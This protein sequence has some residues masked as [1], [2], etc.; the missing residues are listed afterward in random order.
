M[1]LKL[2]SL[3]SQLCSVKS[4]GQGSVLILFNLAELDSVDHSLLLQTS[5]LGL[6]DP[7]G[8]KF[9]SFLT[10]LS[11]LLCW[12][13]P[14]CVCVCVCVCARAR[15]HACLV[16]SLCDPINCSPP[17]S[18]VHGI[19]QARILKWVATCYSRG[20]SQPRDQTCVS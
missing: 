7:V 4:H 6:Q 3:R 11:C 5:S 10:G 20:S 12:L 13:S 8:L 1:P 15:V 2:F 18:S 19:F 14:P 16:V 17:V 9:S